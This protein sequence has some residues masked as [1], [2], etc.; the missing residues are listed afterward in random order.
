MDKKKY[1]YEYNKERY[2]RVKAQMLEVIGKTCVECGSGEN[3]EIDHIDSKKKAFDISV[4][5]AYAWE[6][7]LEELRKCQPLCKA[8][9]II[10]SIN[11][12]GQKVARG[13]HG[14][15][16]AGR[17]CKCE[18]CRAAKNKY[19]REWKR[20]RRLSSIGRAVHL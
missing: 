16:S 20:K 18:L 15:L 14:T 12:R 11:D 1:H 17:Y 10:K 8:C 19:M 9:H 2:R 7:V 13:T 6:A 4:A 5:W 3:I